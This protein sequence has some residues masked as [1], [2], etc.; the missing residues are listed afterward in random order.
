MLCDNEKI[1]LLNSSSFSLY[2]QHYSWT[3]ILSKLKCLQKSSTSTYDH[4]REKISILLACSRWQR[5]I[6]Y[7][8]WAYDFLSM[9]CVASAWLQTSPSPSVSN[10]SDSVLSQHWISHSLSSSTRNHGNR[11][12]SDS[13]LVHI[14]STSSHHWIHHMRHSISAKNS[15]YQKNS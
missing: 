14:R 7:A 1:K 12:S 15:L 13:R 5:H 6:L 9:I 11:K 10:S 8:I 4:E 2:F 3:Q